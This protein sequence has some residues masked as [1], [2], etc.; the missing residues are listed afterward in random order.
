MVA[1]SSSVDPKALVTM[2]PPS[3]AIWLA[4]AENV[5]NPNLAMPR[6]GEAIVREFLA[7]SA[8]SPSPMP[9]SR[10]SLAGFITAKI[11][12]EAIRRAG[13]NPSSADVLKALAQ[14]SNYDVG[15]IMV[16][17]AQDRP[18]GTNYTRLGIINANGVVLN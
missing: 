14:L 3:A 12:T 13:A 7:M 10:T 11:T 17:F 4:V 8:V 5:P 15:G 16:N 18:R 6:R 9:M 2:I 1:T